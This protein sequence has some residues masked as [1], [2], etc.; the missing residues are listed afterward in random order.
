MGNTKKRNC[1]I[2]I[3]KGCAITM[4]TIKKHTLDWYCDRIIRRKEISAGK[5]NQNVKL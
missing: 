5:A 3:V 1:G 2:K 4:E